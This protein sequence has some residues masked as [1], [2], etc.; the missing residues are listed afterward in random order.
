MREK[1][2]R[3]GRRAQRAGEERQR[4]VDAR[5]AA[6]GPSCQVGAA[7][8]GPGAPGDPRPRCHASRASSLARL[9]NRS[10]RSTIHCYRMMSN[11][12][13][14]KVLT[15]RY[16]LSPLRLCAA[17]GRGAAPS[18]SSP[19]GSARCDRRAGPATRLHL[20]DSVDS[21]ARTRGPIHRAQALSSVLHRHRDSNGETQTAHR[22]ADLPRG[23]GAGLLLRGQDGIRPPAAGRGQAL[24]PVASATFRQESL[25]GHVEGALRRQRTAVRGARDPARLGLVRTSSG[26]ASRLQQR[27]LRGP[28]RPAVGAGGAV[29]DPGGGGRGRRSPGRSGRRPLSSPHPDTAPAS[30]PARR[31]ARRRVRQA[32]S[33]RPGCSRYCPGQPRS[34]QRVCTRR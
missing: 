4:L 17:G 12:L 7:R 24:L 23:T 11:V 19:P 29:G 30:G 20:V 8:R 9:T 15:S 10:I 3:L 27:Q 1:A 2:Q 14:G 22:H 18:R 31:R 28:G 26:V 16:F 34:P 6:T 25:P 32:D 13:T 5:I 21:A 33:G